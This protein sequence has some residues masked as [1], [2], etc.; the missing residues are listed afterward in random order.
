[1][2]TVFILN[3]CLGGLLVMAPTF[4]AS[5]F[6][7]E[8]GPKVFGFFWCSF[9]IGN[10]LQY[11]FVVNFEKHITL[12]G[13]IYI[14]LAMNLADLLLVGLYKFEAKWK[15]DTKFFRFKILPAFEIVKD[16]N[17]LLI[18][19]VISNRVKQLELRN[20]LLAESTVYHS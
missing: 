11:I 9:A 7:K 20:S 1:M 8:H 18:Y 3:C 14:C 10:F 2:G 15:N 5:V 12:D 17:E 13:I 6:G 4:S 19:S 16:E